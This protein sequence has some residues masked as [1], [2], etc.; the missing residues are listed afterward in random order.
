[1][2][3][4]KNPYCPKCGQQ[5]KVRYLNKYFKTWQCTSCLI[6]FD[7]SKLESNDKFF[8][9]LDK[10]S[11]VAIVLNPA[12]KISEYRHILDPSRKVKVEQLKNNFKLTTDAKTLSKL[13]DVNAFKKDFY[14]NI[15]K[16]VNILKENN[17]K[18]NARNKK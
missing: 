16:P 15:D 2:K 18:F 11:S 7:F 8:G 13:F 5:D 1:M 17:S 12:S 4:V 10:T 9:I 14:L 6:R 3:I